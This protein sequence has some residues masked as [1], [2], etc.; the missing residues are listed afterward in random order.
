MRYSIEH[1][2]HTR[3]R[4]LQAAA[5]AIRSHGIERVSVA[6]VMAA[7]AALQALAAG[8]GM[9]VDVALREAAAWVAAADPVSQDAWGEAMGRE[10]AWRWANMPLAPASTRPLAAPAAPIGADTRAVLAELA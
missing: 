2:A 8:G 7:V 9:M 3:E 5:E 1:K 6:G 4:I 10:G